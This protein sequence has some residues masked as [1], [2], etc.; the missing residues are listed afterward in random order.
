MSGLTASWLGTEDYAPPPGD[1]IVVSWYSVGQGSPLGAP[2]VALNVEARILAAGPSPLR[3]P[4]LRVTQAAQ[5][6]TTAP[7]PLGAPALRAFH[8]WSTLAETQDMQTYYALEIEGTPP[9]RVPISSWQATIQ[10]D[11]ASYILAVVPAAE[12]WA[13]AISARQG[14]DMVVYKGLRMEDG[15]QS[16]TE[17]ARGPMSIVSYHRGPFRSTASLS[18]YGPAWSGDLV[19]DARTLTGIRSVSQ[20][21]GQLR[22]RANIDFF[23][24]PG[25][26]AIVRGQSLSVAYI[27]YYA[28]AREAYM[29][30]GER[31]S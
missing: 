10:S 23:L 29:D 13:E 3:A 19:T 5:L 15:A 1:A 27:N 24:R 28:N 26:T 17:I 22:A 11:R 25:M 7:S 31:A 8:D 6:L 2:K 30:V 12:Q 21:Q 9:I 18:G 20:S 16:E 14:N 4:S